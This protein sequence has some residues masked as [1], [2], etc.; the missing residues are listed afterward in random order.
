MPKA[1]IVDIAT[2]VPNQALSN[3]ALEARNIG[4]TAAVSV[5]PT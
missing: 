1:V 3:A 4:W 5:L 2:E